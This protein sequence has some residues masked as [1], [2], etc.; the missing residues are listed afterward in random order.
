MGGV[1]I[2]R[3]FMSLIC[4][5]HSFPELC[6]VLCFVWR[7]KKGWTCNANQSL[8]KEAEKILVGLG[9]EEWEE[10]EE[11]DWTEDVISFVSLK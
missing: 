4:R 1:D 9:R 11:E 6:T 10:E 8:K 5:L 2:R 7:T 3:V